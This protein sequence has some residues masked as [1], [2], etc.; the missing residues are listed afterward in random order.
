MLS[1]AILP[2][3]SSLL[4]VLILGMKTKLNSVAILFAVG[5]TLTAGVLAQ[6]TPAA[7]PATAS[8]TGTHH[9]AAAKTSSP[10]VLKTQKEKAS[11]A[12]GMNIAGNMKQNG[13][14]VDTVILLRGMNDVLA[15]DKL[16]L[17]DEEAK[18]ALTTLQ[19]ESRE[20]K[21]AQMKSLGE[22]NQ[23][24]GEAFLAANKT[25]E[26]VVTLPSGVQYKVEKQGDGPKPLSTDT[27]VCNYRGTLI[28]GKEF[29]SSY[30]RG[31]PAT[32][33]VGG[34]IKGWT[35]MLQLMPVGSKYQVFIPAA[36]AYGPRGPSADIGPNATLIFEIELLSIKEKPAAATT[37]D[38]AKPAEPAK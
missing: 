38:A 4:C 30:K 28:N 3:L 10:L 36:L 35:E 25:K 19:Q 13:V 7:K 12:I 15:G 11:Y 14:E 5:I 21:E 27:V 20:K 1:P 8:S 9:K 34:V 33:P 24:E 16:L 6:K 2:L 18:A 29:D 31:Q 23:K 32:F 26:G 37:P 17:T 22:A